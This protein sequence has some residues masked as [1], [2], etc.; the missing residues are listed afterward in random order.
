M[1]QPRARREHLRKEVE[2]HRNHLEELLVAGPV[3][4]SIAKEAAE[5]ADH[6]KT[7][8]LSNMTPELRTPMNAIVGLTELVLGRASDAMQAGQL[9]RVQLAADQQLALLTQIMD[10]TRLQAMQLSL[11]Q[12]P[13]KPTTVLASLSRLLEPD[14]QQKGLAWSTAMQPECADLALRGDAVRLGQVLLAMAGNTIKFTPKGSVVVRVTLAGQTGRDLA[15]SRQLVELMGGPCG[16]NSQP[17]VGFVF[18]FSAHLRKL[19]VTS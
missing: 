2:G 16:V 11:A 5:A 4:L 1:T 15:L 10:I 13:F 14:A 19:E 18:W 12:K 3:A 6:A 8:F 17:G 7:H 9:A